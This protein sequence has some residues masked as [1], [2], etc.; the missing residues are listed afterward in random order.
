MDSR[1]GKPPVLGTHRVL[2]RHW[3]A[4]LWGA[5]LLAC[6]PGVGGRGV[7][8]HYAQASFDSVTVSC[9]NQPALCA[10]SGPYQDQMQDDVYHRLLSVE[11]LQILPRM[12]VVP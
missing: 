1:E 9:R 12:G 4:P 8:R 7:P 6:H 5:L 2:A 10:R 3:V 11:P